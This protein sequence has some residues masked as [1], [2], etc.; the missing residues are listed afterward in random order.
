MFLDFLLKL[1]FVYVERN[2][3]LNVKVGDYLIWALFYKLWLKKLQALLASPEICCVPTEGKT[4]KMEWAAYV[5]ASDGVIPIIEIWEYWST[6]S[7]PLLSGL[8]SPVEQVLVRVL[9]MG[10]I[11]Q[12]KNYLYSI[13][14]C[15]KK[16]K[17]L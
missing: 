4:F 5:S 15:A 13:G 11:D 14:L 12:F 10:Q 16:K 3:A 2:I 8:L 7:L 9:F 17:K 6:S 1:P